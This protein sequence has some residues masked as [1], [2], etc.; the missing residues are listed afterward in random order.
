M[1]LRL[2][3]FY[4]TL[5][6]GLCS[7]SYD[8]FITLLLCCYSL[9]HCFHIGY[10]SKQVSLQM[11]MT[12]VFWKKRKGKDESRKKNLPFCTLPLPVLSSMWLILTLC[13]PPFV[14]PCRRGTDVLI[15]QNCTA[16]FTGWTP[17]STAALPAGANS[18]PPV[19]KHT[20]TKGKG[21]CP[22][23][24]RSF[25]KTDL[26]SYNKNVKKIWARQNTDRWIA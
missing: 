8:T 10:F 5:C 18:C 19:L 2:F 7:Q 23:V 16:P 4:L 15:H 22:T 20:S 1:L 17:A 9:I 26:W 24:T 21:R 11:W 12:H 6:L 25:T 13:Y 3:H 14:W